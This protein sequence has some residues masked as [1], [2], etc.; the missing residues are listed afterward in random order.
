[1][2][3]VWQK[4]DSPEEASVDRTEGPKRAWKLTALQA[5]YAARGSRDALT[6]K[7]R[8]GFRFWES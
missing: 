1:M 7:C 8:S 6:G 4:K 2:N 5:L 3:W